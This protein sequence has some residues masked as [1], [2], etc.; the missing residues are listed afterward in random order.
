MR[1]FPPSMRGAGREISGIS[2]TAPHEAKAVINITTTTITV[3]MFV[4]VFSFIRAGMP[5]ER[6]ESNLLDAFFQINPGIVYGRS[7]LPQVICS[8]GYG[9]HLKI[10]CGKTTCAVL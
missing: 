8:D 3:F 1:G 9:E 5:I 7:N 2:E 10:V 6:S 4:I